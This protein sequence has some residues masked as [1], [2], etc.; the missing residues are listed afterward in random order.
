MKDQHYGSQLLLYFLS[1]QN[2]YLSL[3]V[4]RSLNGPTN[5]IDRKNALSDVVQ[6]QMPKVFHYLSN[7]QTVNIDMFL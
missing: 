3:Q 7:V 4:I 6:Y 1:F 5:L 2:P